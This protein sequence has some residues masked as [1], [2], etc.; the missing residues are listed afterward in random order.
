MFS[1]IYLMYVYF[2]SSQMELSFTGFSPKVTSFGIYWLWFCFNYFFCLSIT[3]IPSYFVKLINT[4]YIDGQTSWSFLRNS[5]LRQMKQ[6]A[7]RQSLF[8]RTVW[9]PSNSFSCD[10]PYPRMD[11]R[12]LLSCFL[13]NSYHENPGQLSPESCGL[14]KLRYINYTRSWRAGGKLT[15]MQHQ[16]SL[17]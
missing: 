15:E 17:I 5:I 2:A 14:N 9:F 8:S 1:I 16:H 4:F 3:S 10:S 7:Q 12:H 11:G 6:E 13:F